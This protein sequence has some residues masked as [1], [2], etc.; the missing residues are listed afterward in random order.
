MATIKD[1]A[2]KAG[3][4]TATVSAVVNQSAYVSPELRLRVEQAI[5]ELGY[6]PSRAARVLR[7]GRSELIAISVADL[8]NPFYADIV[9]A[10]EAA[11]ARA[12]YALV[13]FNSDERLEI[14]RSIIGRARILGCDG[15]ILVPSGGPGDYQPGYLDATPPKV[16][17]GR[18]LGESG[19]DNVTIDN[20]AAGRQVTDYLLDLGHVK[21]GSITG[22][23]SVST[24]EGRLAGML[25]AMAARGLTPDPR[26]IRTGEF[27]EEL[28]YCVAHEMLAREDR[29]TALYVANGVMALGVMRAL[30]DLGLACPR[31]ISIVSTDT[32]AGHG[33]I[34]PRL[35]RSE[36]PVAEMTAEAVRLL[37]E[38]IEGPGG[39]EPRRLTFPPSLVVGDSCRP[40]H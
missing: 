3:V 29:P 4:S 32:V 12:G 5:D 25:K 13:V 18:T 15:I 34:S 11:V 36:H 38:R 37:I 9:R 14:E 31:D 17:V 19:L 27:R 1:V 6:L 23:Q 39:G 40:L 35:T 26:H 33:G 24:G 22:R 16:L 20:V 8:S 28:A 10:A 2:R 21:I 30:R 7:K